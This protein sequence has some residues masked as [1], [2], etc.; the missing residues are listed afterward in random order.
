M[1]E[2]FCSPIFF[3]CKDSP[4]FFFQPFHQF[5][6]VLVVG[7]WNRIFRTERSLSDRVILRCG[8]D[9]TQI[10]MREAEAVRAAKDR[11][12]IPGR[13]DVVDK[14]RNLSSTRWA[15]R[16]GFSHQLAA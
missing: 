1:V 9:A 15:R 16:F 12:N 2:L 5:D 14:Y 10:S 3:Q 6:R 8:C 13:T 11:A 4:A 7:P